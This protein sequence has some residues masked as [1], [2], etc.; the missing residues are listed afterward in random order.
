MS[1]KKMRDCEVLSLR[2][3]GVEMARLDNA[4]RQSEDCFNRS[5][6]LRK[7]VNAYAGKTLLEE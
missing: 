4:W 6:Y 3:K 5:D 7:A 2:V 1:R